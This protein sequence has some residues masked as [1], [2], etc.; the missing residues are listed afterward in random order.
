MKM[1]A[2]FFLDLPQTLFVTVVAV[3]L[4]SRNA[5]SLRKA[6]RHRETLMALQ[7]YLQEVPHLFIGLLGSPDAVQELCA[8]FLKIPPCPSTPSSDSLKSNNLVILF[9]L[10]LN[11]ELQATLHYGTIQRLVFVDELQGCRYISEPI[12]WLEYQHR[13]HR[14]VSYFQS[15]TI[16]IYDR[17]DF[18]SKVNHTEDSRCG[19][20]EVLCAI[21]QQL[22]ST[23]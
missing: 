22:C 2:H 14:Y 21:T 19:P 15:D 17:E 13:R 23:S 1:F 10:L 9:V 5:R 16:V 4:I 20:M 6:Y 3:T 7:H 11:P 8:K 12:V 18:L